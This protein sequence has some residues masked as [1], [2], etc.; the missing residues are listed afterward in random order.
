MTHTGNPFDNG[1]VSD[2][3]CRP[4]VDV[5]SIYRSVSELCHDLVEDV[6][7]HGK[8]R[9]LLIHGTAGSGKTHLLARLRAAFTTEPPVGPPRRE[10]PPFFCYVRLATATN[11]IRD[12]RPSRPHH[13]SPLR[14]PAAQ[15]GHLGRP[16]PR[17][18][19]HAARSSWRRRAH[20]V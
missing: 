10:P 4:A 8:R 6:H 11:M 3:W 14:A 16:G 13:P 1:I 2:A 7:R 12:P 19:V 17:P 9:S 20:A 5:P 15:G 18:K